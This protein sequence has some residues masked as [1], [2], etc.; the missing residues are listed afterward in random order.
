MRGSTEKKTRA[1][2]KSFRTRAASVVRAL[3]PFARRHR[4]PFVLGSV[5]ALGV[6]LLR[7]ALPWPLRA[8]MKPWMSG[9][10]DGA[11]GALGSLAQG[12]PPVVLMAALLLVVMVA[13]GMADHFQRWNYARFAIGFVRDVRAEVL[14]RAVAAGPGAR[15]LGSGDF[16]ARLIGDTARLKAGLKGFLVHVATNGAM[17][18]GVTAILLWMDPGI[19]AIFAAAGVVVGTATWWG[20]AITFRRALRYRKKEGKLADRIDE[21]WKGEALESSLKINRTSGRYEATLTKIQGRFTW[22]A[23]SALGTAILG[24]AVAGS[25]AVDAGRIEAGDLFVVLVYALMLRAPIVQLT[26]QGVRTGKILACGHRLKRLLKKKSPRPPAITPPE[27]ER[28]SLA[29]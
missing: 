27:V 15:E 8:V 6:V 13:L 12:L 14:R 5:S 19:G 1:R 17:F 28:T 23:H 22:L 2:R 29:S 24:G 18:V 9:A 20:A 7:V 25:R 21:A 4:G 11:A 26:R 10:D 16:V 3:R